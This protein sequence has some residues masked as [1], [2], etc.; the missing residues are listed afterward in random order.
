LG[1]KH[2]YKEAWSNEAIKNFIIEQI[3]QM[4][5]QMIADALIEQFDFFVNI[6]VENP[7]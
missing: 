4:F 7:D 2:C 1:S 5:D 6:R 3:G